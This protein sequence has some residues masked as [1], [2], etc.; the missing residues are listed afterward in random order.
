M[1]AG[2]GASSS[3]SARF[4]EE[5]LLPILSG[6]SSIF[7][8]CRRTICR[9]IRR[10][11]SMR[12]PSLGYPV[13]WWIDQEA[14]PWF[15]NSELWV[16]AKDP[17]MTDLQEFVCAGFL[18]TLPFAGPCRRPNPRPR[19]RPGAAADHPDGRNMSDEVS[20]LR[21]LAE[22]APVIELVNNLIGQAFDGGASDIHVEP[23]EDDFRVRFR[24][25]GVLQTRLT[26]PRDRFDAVASRIKLVSGLDIAERRLPQDGRLGLRLERRN[27]RHP[28]LI[29]AEHLGRIVG[30]A[31]AAEGAQAIPAR[32][33]RHDSQRPCAVQS[34]DP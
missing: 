2:W 26:L 19:P 7:R 8:C 22:E 29:V 1:A 34:L 5:R 14:L 21:E 3:G 32:P 25:D 16:V 13:D 4:S 12:S 9:R 11:I 31:P 28:R 30:A 6:V 18:G 20:H 24:L 27:G 33:P 10:P 17:L 23:A 15:T